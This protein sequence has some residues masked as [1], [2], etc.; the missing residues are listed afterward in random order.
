MCVCHKILKNLRFCIVILTV[1]NSS[2]FLEERA[3]RIN[4]CI[5]L[6]LL[7]SIVEPFIGL[8]VNELTSHRLRGI[9]WFLIRSVK[10][11]PN[12]TIPL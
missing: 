6:L 2:V 9:Q 8:G 7:V 5:L 3:L 11:F 12:I 4:L 1:E 10:E